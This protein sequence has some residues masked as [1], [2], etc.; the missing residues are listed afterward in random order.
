MASGSGG[1]CSG[2]MRLYA[3][4][5]TDV[6]RVPAAAI[7]EQG[8][9]LGKARSIGLTILLTIVTFGIW[10]FFWSYRTGE[11][12]K[13]YRHDG[14][15][16]V[17]YALINLVFSPAVMFLMADEVAKL[18][19]DAGEEPPITAV[20]GFWVLLP[21]IGHFIWYIRIQNALN[22]FWTVRGAPYATGV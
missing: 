4:T 15:G 9:P 8:R 3:G 19:Q 10:T 21:L 5:M 22:T 14:L 2:S 11:D 6:P 17:A 18:Y 20:W 7:P 16:G 12:L 1:N 13:R